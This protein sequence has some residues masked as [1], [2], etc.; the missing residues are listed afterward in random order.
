MNTTFT[1]TAATLIKDILAAKAQGKM[2]SYQALD[3]AGLALVE[4]DAKIQKQLRMIAIHVLDGTPVSF[5]EDFG[6]K[7][8]MVLSKCPECFDSM[9]LYSGAPIEEISFAVE[10]DHSLRIKM[11]L[12]EGV[13]V[14]GSVENKTKE[15]TTMTAQELINK[16]QEAKTK[17]HVTTYSALRYAGVDIKQVSPGRQN[18][19]RLF[20]VNALDNTLNITSYSF[21]NELQELISKCPAC[22]NSKS[23]NDKLSIFPKEKEVEY[24]DKLRAEIAP[25]N[26]S[27]SE[28]VQEEEIPYT[29]TMPAM[30]ETPVAE[31]TIKEGETMTNTQDVSNVLAESQQEEKKGKKSKKKAKE[32]VTL[33]IVSI[34]ECKKSHG[35]VLSRFEDAMNYVI[36]QP[37]FKGKSKLKEALLDA[38]QEDPNNLIAFLR[39]PEDFGIAKASITKYITPILDAVKIP[40]K[41][42]SRAKFDQ[43]L[44]LE[45]DFDQADLSNDSK[46]ATVDASYARR[47]ESL[48]L[49]TAAGMKQIKVKVKTAAGHI[50]ERYMWDARS[51]VY[52]TSSEDSAPTYAGI[53]KG[54]IELQV[55]EPLGDDF[56]AHEQMIRSASNRRLMQGTFIRSEA[57]KF[58]ARLALLTEIGGHPSTLGKEVDAAKDRTSLAASNSIGTGLFMGKEIIDAPE[59]H[60]GAYYVKG[61]DITILVAKDVKSI[62]RHGKYFAINKETKQLV[63]RDASVEGQEIEQEITDGLALASERIKTFFDAFAGKPTAGGQFRLAPANKGFM[64]FVPFLERYFPGVDLILFESTVKVDIRKFLEACPDA[65]AELRF[66]NFA[67]KKTTQNLEL[68]Y[69]AIHTTA[70]SAKQAIDIAKPALDKYT[71]V[72]TNPAAL[73]SILNKVGQKEQHTLLDKMLTESKLAAQDPY[74]MKSAVSEAKES[75]SRLKQGKLPIQG[76]FKFMLSDVFAIIDA[77][78]DGSFMVEEGAG[79]K[80]GTAFTLKDGKIMIAGIKFATNRFPA[81]SLGEG[82]GVVSPEHEDIDPRYLEAVALNKGYFVNV[83]CYSAHDFMAQKQGGADFDG[84]KSV[85]IFVK[86]Y[87]DSIFAIQDKFAPV[88]DFTIMENGTMEAGCKWEDKIDIPTVVGTPGIVFQD[89]YKLIVSEWTPEA[90]A[91]FLM[92]QDFYDSLTLQ[93]NRIGEFTDYSTMLHDALRAVLSELRVAYKQENEQL[94]AKLEWEKKTIINWQGYGR[95]VQGYEIDR[96]KKGGAFEIALAEQLKFI[97]DPGAL[98]YRLGEWVQPEEGGDAYFQWARPIWMKKGNKNHKKDSV[99]TGLYMDIEKRMKNLDDA[100]KI[101]TINLSKNNVILTAMASKIVFRNDIY[102]MLQ[103][104]ILKRDT[105]YFKEIE[106]LV[107]RREDAIKD[108]E[109]ELTKQQQKDFQDEFTVIFEKYTGIMDE[110]FENA[111]LRDVT[112]EEF[113]FYVYK[114]VTERGREQDT[115]K[116]YEGRSFPFRAALEYVYAAFMAAEGKTARPGHLDVFKGRKLEVAGNRRSNAGLLS[117]NFHADRATL[118]REG[119]YMA[120]AFEN[121]VVVDLYPSYNVGFGDYE[122]VV[123]VNKVVLPTTAAKK[124]NMRVMLEVTLG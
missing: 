86:A 81:V 28:E 14:V 121:G 120:L 101:Q 88:L 119:E 108:A 16:I 85:V 11:G 84:D 43:I 61:G 117:D 100:V 2:T 65:E 118:V 42:F 48:L 18:K 1:A 112:V 9:A 68:S 62:V 22:F 76:E 95:L 35:F 4:A 74:I 32:S 37:G 20:A 47:S 44:V 17:G 80:A 116:V 25:A 3:H 71:A 31:N 105:A 51:I 102:K 12:I 70:L 15:E 67:A 111:T 115:T 90:V 63:L 82:A 79:L 29:V 50:E 75:L 53:L 46:V 99:M 83:I 13:G 23:L 33:D 21:V 36:D 97:T 78:L 122:G 106:K 5:G 39:N 40:K 52:V 98:A 58:D 113:G 107:E 114:A 38:T 87:V 91:A 109:G 92:L 96:P 64:T 24:D 54:Q 7:V 56:V 41:K 49:E 94:I 19:F 89:D 77:M 66:M 59:I 103:G 93:K 69:Q 55:K 8:D 10:E 34:E 104:P 124:G 27:V 110:L 72:P 26:I 6:A 123:K 57:N 45:A 73:L 30:G 60:E